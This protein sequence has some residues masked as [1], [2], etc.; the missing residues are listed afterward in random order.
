MQVYRHLDHGAAKSQCKPSEN[1]K[2]ET[3]QKF[4]AAIRDFA[5]T[6]VA[7]QSKRHSADYD[8]FAP[9]LKLSAVKADLESARAAVTAFNAVTALNRAAFAA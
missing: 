6:F 1:P 7:M 8:P 3:F 5:N 4:P 9:K 2:K